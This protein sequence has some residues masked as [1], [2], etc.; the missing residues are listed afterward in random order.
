MNNRWLAGA[1]LLG[2]LGVAGF[3]SVDAFLLSR[4]RLRVGDPWMPS[5]VHGTVRNGVARHILVYSPHCKWCARQMPQLEE[6][7]AQDSSIELV[8]LVIEDFDTARR[9]LAGFDASH[10]IDFVER[11]PLQKEIGPIATPMH[12]IVDSTGHVAAIHQGYLAAEALTVLR[13][14]AELTTSNVR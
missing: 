13:S 4:A 12:V 14:A 9:K 10:Q 5:G 3:V 1:L 7:A 8:I 11:R 2:I 6:A